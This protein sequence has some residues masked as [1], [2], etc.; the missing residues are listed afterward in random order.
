MH[1]VS[2]MEAT[3]SLALDHAKAQGAQKIHRLGL[4]VGERSGIVPEA[5]S[6]AFDVVSPGTLAAGATLQLETVPALCYCDRCQQ[7]FRPEDWVYACPRCQLLSTTVCQGDS[8][9]LTLL[10]MS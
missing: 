5:L 8:L 3:L 7:T 10:E 1:E 9:D 4:Q 6:F 2:L